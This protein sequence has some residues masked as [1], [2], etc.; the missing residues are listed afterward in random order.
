VRLAGFNGKFTPVTLP[1]IARNRTPEMTVRETVEDNLHDAL[2]H[3]AE[4]QST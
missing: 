1:D 4:L 3:L 2:K